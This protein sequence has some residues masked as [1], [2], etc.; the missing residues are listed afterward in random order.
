VLVPE[1]ALS[2]F[3]WPSDFTTNCFLDWKSLAIVILLLDFRRLH[4]A[5]HLLMEC[6][7]LS[8]LLGQT[9]SLI[10]LDL[11]IHLLLDNLVIEHVFVG[12]L[13]FL[14]VHALL[15]DLLVSVYFLLL[16]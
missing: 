2:F 15:F 6:C 11:L 8:A 14:L 3:G 1:G 10:G 16:F 7:S 9:L 5:L 13:H 4:L 12:T